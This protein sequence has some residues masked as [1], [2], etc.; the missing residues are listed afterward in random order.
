M[1]APIKQVL[2]NNVTQNGQQGRIVELTDGKKVFLVGSS[3]PNANTVQARTIDTGFSSI[4][5]PINTGISAFT[6]PTT[7]F[8]PVSSESL[9][10]QAEEEVTPFYEK[11]LQMALKQLT[12]LKE[13]K[14]Q[15][16]EQERKQQEE[17]AG[18]WKNQEEFNFMNTL[19][20][21]QNGYA[22]RGTFGS[23]IQAGGIENLQK[24]EDLNRVQPFNLG[25]K[26]TTE[27]RDLG[28][29]Q[30][31]QQNEYDV[32]KARYLNEVAKNSAIEGDIRSIQSAE[33]AKNNYSV[34]ALQSAFS[35]FL[36]NNQRLAA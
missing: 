33:Q 9:R 19:K 10:S 5:N 36:G 4:L 3:A 2:Q 31:L 20:S 18:L 35:Q 34:G 23:G 14:T 25:Q 16:V 27:T 6:P 13:Q 1:A 11:Q 17:G 8:E 30:F 29:S 24:S 21:A 15:I 32:E 26:Q 12:I 28:F 7:L 22:G